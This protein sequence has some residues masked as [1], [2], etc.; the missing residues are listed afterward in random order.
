MEPGICVMVYSY[1]DYT[2]PVLLFFRREGTAGHWR[3]SIS[4]WGSPPPLLGA[5]IWFG[6]GSAFC[7]SGRDG[8][9]V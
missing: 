7:V 6:A 5:D 4:P 9:M 3:P 2:Q 8:G 1:R